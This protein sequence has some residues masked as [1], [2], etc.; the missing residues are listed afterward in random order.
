[1]PGRLSGRL[2]AGA[3]ASLVAAGAALGGVLA[4]LENASVDA[5]FDMRH[6]PPVTDIVIVGIDVSSIKRAPNGIWPFRRLR[7]A[8]A[9]ARLHA[10]DVRH[11]VYDVQFTEPSPRPADDL[12]LYDA[13]GRA[14]GATL[15]T[16][17]SDEEGNTDVLG[18]DENLAQIRSRAA[19]A[20]L[21]NQAGVIRRYPERVG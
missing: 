17:L 21:P 18:G 13:I 11:I 12:A 8:Q 10:A 19:A 5:R 2:L 7:H 1:V 6:S 3:A 9:V 20:D 4:P 14:G 16:S 15:A